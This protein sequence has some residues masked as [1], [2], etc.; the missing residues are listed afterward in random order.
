[1]CA[2]PSIGGVVGGWSGGGVGDTSFTHEHPRRTLSGAASS[3]AAH[4]TAGSEACCC[5][6]SMASFA[7]GPLEGVAPVRLR[8]VIDTDTRGR[9]QCTL[10][11][12]GRLPYGVRRGR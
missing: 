6:G 5:A 2:S 10:S 12:L 8:A 3:S 1:M 11:P 7:A 9:S 4:A